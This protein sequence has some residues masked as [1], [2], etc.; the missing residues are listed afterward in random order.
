MAGRTRWLTTIAV[1]VVAGLTAVAPAQAVSV[2]LGPPT[3]TASTSSAVCSIGQ[4]ACSYIF[5]SIAAPGAVL[6]APADGTITAWRLMANAAGVT[7]FVAHPDGDAWSATQESAPATSLNGTAMT[8]SLPVT[9]GDRIGAILRGGN[10]AA[11]AAPTAIRLYFNGA[12]GAH[13]E[14]AHPDLH[15]L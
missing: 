4:P 13:A 11:I 2:R 8:T 9:A 1:A 6:Q 15:R 12:L 7:L 14:H 5:G 3:L 10:V